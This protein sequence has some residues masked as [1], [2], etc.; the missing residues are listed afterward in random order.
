MGKKQKGL[1]SV[2][3]YHSVAA[4]DR[5]RFARQMDVLLTLA[6][7]VDIAKPN[8][9]IIQGR[10]VAVTFDDGL[11]SFKENALSELVKRRIPV[12]L[13]IPSRCLG[14]RLSVY[15]DE[16]V[17][18]QEDL[19]NLPVD[20]VTI[21]SHSQTHTNLTILDYD[22]AR[23]EIGESKTDLETL[24]GREVLIF[25]FPYGEYNEQILS[26]ARQAGYLRTFSVLP[27]GGNDFL[28][29]RIITSPKDWMI[30][31]RLKALGAYRWL[32][33]AVFFKKQFK[34]FFRG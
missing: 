22:E 33:L 14:K 30:E 11:Q 28:F 24:L 21:G 25:A 10:Q 17:M 6:T 31:F 7:P 16:T 12:A 27:T 5:E 13:F 23:K 9:E 8:P 19:L 2:L 4:H 26:L 3:L 34:K 1:C 18:N 29:G 32:P 15:D 20:L